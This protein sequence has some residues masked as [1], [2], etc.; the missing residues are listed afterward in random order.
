MEW[1]TDKLKSRTNRLAKDTGDE[2][3]LK[4]IAR[5]PGLLATEYSGSETCCRQ[6]FQLLESFP[7]DMT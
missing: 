7:T 4:I 2:C 3:G 5:S 1:L 6:R